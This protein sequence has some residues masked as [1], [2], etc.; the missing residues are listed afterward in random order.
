MSQYKNLFN[1]TR[2]PKI[3]KDE[4]ILDISAKHIVVL[5][6]GHF[7]SLDVLDKNGY[8]ISPLEL[9]SNI[10]YILEDTTSQVETS[11]GVLTASNRNT[12]ASAR[13][14]IENIGNQDILKKIDSA[15]FVLILEDEVMGQN[16]DKLLRTFLYGKPENRWFDK[17]L[18][19]IVTKDGFGGIN[20]EHS[21]GDGVAV[22]RYFQDIKKD[23]SEKP[24]FRPEDKKQLFT[25]SINVH[26][27]EFKLDEKSKS[28]ISE[29]KLNF[30]KWVSGL[31][32]DFLIYEG[33]G[34]KECKN[35]GVSP[36][37]VMQFVFQLALFKQEFR[38]VGTYESCS[39]SAFKHGRTE[40]VRSCTLQTKNL[41]SAMAKRTNDV[42]VAEIKKMI[43][44]CSAAH[45]TLVKEAAMGKRIAY[46]IKTT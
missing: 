13:V 23:I 39:T 4:I 19:L 22:L 43:V 14:H 24:L 36:D 25:K 5:R 45:M 20:F 34:K 40:T 17:S 7:Y 16:Q 33:F 9:A 44:D 3:D 12:W 11:V 28:I 26:K 15:A 42:S 18:S 35:F 10:N 32:I 41:C 2:I 46:E 29:E 21:W 31:D 1:S 37:A 38:S 6:N 27:L 30:E 8:I